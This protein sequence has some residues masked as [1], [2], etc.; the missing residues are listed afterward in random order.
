MNT[1]EQLNAVKLALEVLTKFRNGE[2]ERHQAKA[3]LYALNIGVTIEDP[4][5]PRAA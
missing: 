5:A 3:L 2:L 4:G 1:A